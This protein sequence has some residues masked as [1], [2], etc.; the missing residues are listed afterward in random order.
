M[1][2]ARK[3]K[4]PKGLDPAIVE[5]ILWFSRFTPLEKIAIYEKQN[6][7]VKRFKGLALKCIRDTSLKQ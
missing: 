7:W 6:E 1:K 4:I 5:N 2:K 3:P